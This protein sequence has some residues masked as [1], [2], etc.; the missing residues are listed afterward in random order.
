MR[1]FRRPAGGPV[2]PEMQRSSPSKSNPQKEVSSTQRWKTVSWASGATIACLVVVGCA[3]SLQAAKEAARAHGEARKTLDSWSSVQLRHVTAAVA[4]ATERAIDKAG[5]AR[6]D[7]ETAYGLSLAAA[8][9]S[10]K[11]ADEPSRSTARAA[12]GAHGAA[13]LAWEKSVIARSPRTGLL[14]DLRTLED[15]G[16]LILVMLF[17][18]GFLAWAIVPALFRAMR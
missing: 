10:Q 7:S 14:G 15:F 11:F 18:I 8:G 9:A 16:D 13:A 2:R 4:T 12:S 3:G 6:R 5:I 17:V 1:L